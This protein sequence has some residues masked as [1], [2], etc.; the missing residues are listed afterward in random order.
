MHL[1]LIQQHE[2]QLFYPSPKGSQLIFFTLFRAGANK[3]NQV[4]FWVHEQITIKLNFQFFLSGRDDA[5]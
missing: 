5:H 1:I 4:L 3:E 2:N